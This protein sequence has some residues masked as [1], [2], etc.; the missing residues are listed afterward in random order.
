MTARGGTM[1]NFQ[2][3]P[4]F[5]RPGSVLSSK[6]EKE[7]AEATFTI[8]FDKKK[9]I[10][11]EIGRRLCAEIKIDVD[12]ILPKRLVD[13]KDQYGGDEEV[14]KMYF[15]HH[16]NRRQKHLLRICKYYQETAKPEVTTVLKP[17]PVKVLTKAH[18]GLDLQS[19]IRMSLERVNEIVKTRKA[20]EEIVQ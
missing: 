9:Q 17:S 12:K 3:P 1:S 8:L 19:K 18:S 13:F 4:L 11:T 10:I 6:Q 15:K 16:N 14:A 2:M 7:Q 5:P 20:K